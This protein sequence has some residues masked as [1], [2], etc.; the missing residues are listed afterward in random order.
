MNTGDAFYHADTV[1]EVMRV[2]VSQRIRPMVIPVCCLD[3]TI[4]SVSVGAIKGAGS[5]VTKDMP[6]YAILG[7]VP[8]KLIRYR[9]TAMAP[10]G[11]NFAGTCAQ[12]NLKAV[13]S[14]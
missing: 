9:F 4:A 13:S 6:H 8:E 10:A 12:R 11:K 3:L 14:N 5:V 2:H 7:G 1:R